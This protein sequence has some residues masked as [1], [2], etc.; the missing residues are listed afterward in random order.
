MQRTAIYSQSFWRTLAWGL[1]VYL[2]AILLCTRT[3]ALDPSYQISQYAHTAWRIRDGFLG[4]VPEV[5]T[6]TTDGYLWIGTPSGLL[7]FDGVRFVPWTPPDGQQ[8][9]R[10]D[11]KSL[12]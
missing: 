8:L 2:V 12:L 9:P 1:S 6:Q 11:I 3:S 7:R 10:T 5:I 4:D